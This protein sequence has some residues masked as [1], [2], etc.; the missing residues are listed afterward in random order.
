MFLVVTRKVY[1]KYAIER[2]IF[3]GGYYG[4]GIYKSI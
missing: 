3:L 1:K 4:T 2:T